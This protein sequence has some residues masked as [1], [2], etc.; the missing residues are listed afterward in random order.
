[1]L[2]TSYAAKQLFQSQGLGAMKLASEVA[3]TSFNGSSSPYT[4]PD[5]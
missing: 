2:Q 3:V 4:G 5:P 1:M